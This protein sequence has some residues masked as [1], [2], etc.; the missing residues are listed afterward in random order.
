MDWF[1][2]DS[3]IIFTKSQKTKFS[4]NPLNPLCNPITFGCSPEIPHSV[5]VTQHL[6]CEKYR[7]FGASRC[8]VS[9]KTALLMCVKIQ[10]MQV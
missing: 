3:N 6:F 7:K 2:A 4:L 9:L 8:I 1:A 5:S 10:S